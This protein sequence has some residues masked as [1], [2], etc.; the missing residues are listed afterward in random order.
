VT[1]L[2][3]LYRP[4]EDYF[5][6][7]ISLKYLNL[8]DGANIAGSIFTAGKWQFSTLFDILA[9]SRKMPLLKA[10]FEGV[11]NVR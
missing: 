8:D 11:L 1:D 9:P 6:R 7:G 10:Y 3:N 5:F 2:I 4:A